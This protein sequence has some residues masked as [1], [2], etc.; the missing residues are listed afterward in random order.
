MFSRFLSFFDLTSF[1]KRPGRGPHARLSELCYVRYDCMHNVQPE[2]HTV[3]RSVRVGQDWVLW[4]RF[5]WPFHVLGTCHG[6]HVSNPGAACE[7]QRPPAERH[8]GIYKGPN[9]PQAADSTIHLCG[10]SGDPQGPVFTK[11]SLLSVPPP[12]STGETH[13]AT[14]TVP[15]VSPLAYFPSV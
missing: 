3:F 2:I 8:W 1:P 7:C 14:C 5:V 10:I 13:V 12:S 4:I 9:L 15:K 11:V 6:D